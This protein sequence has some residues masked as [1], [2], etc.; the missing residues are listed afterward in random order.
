MG[1]RKVSTGGELFMLQTLFTKVV[2]HTKL[3][4]SGVL[5]FVSA[6]LGIPSNRPTSIPTEKITLDE[7]GSSNN[8]TTPNPTKTPNTQKQ[9]VQPT[10]TRK[11]TALPVSTTLIFT[12]TSTPVPTPSYNDLHCPKIIEINDSLGNI[13]NRSTGWNGITGS[14]KRGETS[15]LRLTVT[16]QDP[17][18]LPV[19]YRFDSLGLENS[20]QRSVTTKDWSQDNFVDISVTNAIPG[21]RRYIAVTA[22]NRDGYSCYGSYDLYESAWYEVFP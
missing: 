8:V 2:L 20:D 10:P 18:N 7:T 11:S 6:H 22:D 9:T 17:Q 12:S 14:F 5:L 19:F 13:S 4:I 15:Q 3:F 21:T 16:I 1:Y